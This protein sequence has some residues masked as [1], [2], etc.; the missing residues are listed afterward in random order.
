[1]PKSE[2]IRNFIIHKEYKHLTTLRLQYASMKQLLL[3]S[4]IYQQSMIGM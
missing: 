2:I 4:T 1:M 3:E